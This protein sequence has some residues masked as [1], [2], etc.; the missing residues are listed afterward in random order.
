MDP[1]QSSDDDNEV[2]SSVNDK[3]N[4]LN[5]NANSV[6]LSHYYQHK[7]EPSHRLL[8]KT[9]KIYNFLI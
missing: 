6:K 7:R 2:I 4:Q 1:A 3:K 9:I 5:N 8:S